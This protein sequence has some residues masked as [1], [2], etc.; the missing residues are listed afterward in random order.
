MPSQ[1]VRSSAKASRAVFGSSQRSM[2]GR[3]PALLMTP[4]DENL[5]SRGFS[6]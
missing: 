5:A 6:Q 2:T 3:T 1:Y 4:V